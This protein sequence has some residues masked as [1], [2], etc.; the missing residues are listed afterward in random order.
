VKI[1]VLDRRLWLPAPPAR[2]FE[3][4]VDAAN[5]ERLTPPALRFEMLTPGP[6]VLALGSRLEFRLRVH[7]LPLSWQSEITRLEPP[8]LFVDEQPRG[9]YRLWLHQH[10][11]EPRDG[12]T[13]VRDYVRWSVPLASVL[14]PWV[15]RDLARIFD[16]R[17]EVLRRELGG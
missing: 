3:F 4:F 16:Y 11:F 1:F 8:A 10:L 2:V 6:L 7:G 15:E 13:A 9:P 17:A 12:G 5:L 14:R